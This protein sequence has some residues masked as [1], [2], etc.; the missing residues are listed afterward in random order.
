MSTPTTIQKM[1]KEMSYTKRLLQVMIVCCFLFPLSAHAQ[2]WDFEVELYMMASNIE[3]DAGI[4]R[5]GA[6]SVD[7]D[8]GTILENLKLGGAMH[9]EAI[10]ESG[11]GT[12]LDY[13]FVDLG[14][15]ITGAQGGV[16]DV[17]VRQGVLQA[18][19]LYRMP[20]A[21]GT[22]DWLGGIRWW[23]NNIDLTV[24]AA[25]LPGPVD[26]EVEEDWIDVFVGARWIYA[27]TDSW[28]LMVRGDIGGFGLESDFTAQL[29][30]N[31]RWG[32][33]DRWALDLGYKAI[34][35]DY[36]SGTVGQPGYFLYDTVT[37]G[38]VMGIVFKF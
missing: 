17:G 20:V 33:A 26:I 24:D 23:D 22:V 8:F 32:F 7:V 28:E 34:W 12:A 14:S 30:G 13:S 25:V 29:Y 21:K 35:V 37:H 19:L 4:G 11:W 9:F 5:A 16:A 3:G 2:G 38:P 31:V 10:H 18:D 15:D 27:F 36:E 1:E 6:T